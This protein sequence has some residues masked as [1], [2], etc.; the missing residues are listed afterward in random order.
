MKRIFVPAVVAVL[1]ICGVCVYA[2]ETGYGRDAV[3]AET[4]EKATER[5]GDDE[6]TIVIP[7]SD[8]GED[9]FTIT[10]S[11]KEPI[12][13]T[14]A[15]GSESSIEGGTEKSIP[16]SKKVTF[17]NLGEEA[18]AEIKNSTYFCSF[19]VTNAESVVANVS[20]G[21]TIN[22][23]DYGYQLT[24][25][26]KNGSKKLSFT[27]SLTGA[28][29]AEYSGNDIVLNSNL[30]LGKI[31]VTAENG[32]A[33]NY[34]VNKT[35]CVIHTDG[36]ASLEDGTALPALSEEEIANSGGTSVQNVFH[37]ISP[38]LFVSGSVS[39]AA[40]LINDYVYGDETRASKLDEETAVKSVKYYGETGRLLFTIT[41]YASGNHARIATAD[42]ETHDYIMEAQ[43]GAHCYPI[44]S[45]G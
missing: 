43:E 3:K 20:N 8:I 45:M 17:T 34:L 21:V 1:C 44:F 29:N 40:K 27:G 24:M 15:D 10:S 14:A 18:S 32:A 9:D 42:G 23:D 28:L 38:A 33:K 7:E 2:V 41:V 13:V 25:K 36:S 30:V 26:T 6:Y 37:T 4:I 19:K 35:E 39:D 22:G 16:F 11:G 5:E 12:T 31:V